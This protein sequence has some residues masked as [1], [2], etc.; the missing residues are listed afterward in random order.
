MSQRCY[1]WEDKHIHARDQS[2]VPFDQAQSI[3][4]YVWSKAGL[5][6][7]PKIGPLSKN[8]K[9][10]R[11]NASRLQIRIPKSGIKTTILLHE[12]AHSMTSDA[13]GASEH[14][15]PRFVGVFMHLLCEHIPTFQLA[16]LRCTAKLESVDFNFDGP[17][18][19]C[20]DN[21]P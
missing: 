1:R 4:D 7:P 10:T 21:A 9:K 3:V 14:H 16:Q 19:T 5:S 8:A 20:D 17:N 6:Y 12:I 13:L 15:G 18:I 11:A 2:V